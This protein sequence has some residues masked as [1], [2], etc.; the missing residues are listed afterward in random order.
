MTFA[1]Q[2]FLLSPDPSCAIK[3]GLALRP[4]F[5]PCCLSSHLS[6]MQ[7]PLPV[8]RPLAWVGSSGRYLPFPG[9]P[10]YS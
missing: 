6:P 9:A 7:F 8:Q 5:L 2:A 3:L 4:H 10:L 1:L